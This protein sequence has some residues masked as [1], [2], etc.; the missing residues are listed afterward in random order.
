MINGELLLDTNNNPIHAHGGYLVEADGGFY[1]YGENR[2][3]DNY[4]SCYFS[5]DL[6]AWEFKN[7]ILTIKS[8]SVQTRVKADLSLVNVNG[9]KVNIER[10]K[11]FY[12]KKINRYVMWA[13]YENGIDYSMACVCIAS[14]ER[15]DGDFEFHGAFRPFGNMS[16]DCTVYEEAGQM[17]FASASRDNADMNLYLIAEDGLNVEKQL[18]SYYSNEYRE[19]PAFFRRRGFTYF[20]S[21]FCTGWAPNQC[22]YAMGKDILSC[23]NLLEN[24]G[25][26]TAYDSQVAFI[27]P[28]RLNGETFY[29]YVGDRW[30][31]LDYHKSGYVIYPIEFDTEGRARLIKCSSIAIDVEN[32]KIIYN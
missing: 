22:K 5:K 25:D 4:V 29:L 26:E 14:C 2:T 17:Y 31:A 27:Y 23:F 32:K 3:A 12:N 8:K 19:A 24:I 11:V 13:H 9:N 21:S 7:N 15:A 30:D 6:K 1:W 20:F 10:P 16:R 18:G 28:L